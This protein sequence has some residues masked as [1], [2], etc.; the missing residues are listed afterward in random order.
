M[1]VAA[2]AIPVP[3]LACGGTVM[4]LCR[5]QWGACPRQELY[6]PGDEVEWARL[7]DGSVAPPFRLLDGRWNSGDPSCT[8]MLIKDPTLL[9]GPIRCP[10]CEASYEGVAVEIRAGRFASAHLYAC[11]ELPDEADAFER[12]PDGSLRGHPEWQNAPVFPIAG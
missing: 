11:D 2:L 4:D 9:G 12:Q 10:A 1:D 3:C 6:R 8:E 5:L 7:P